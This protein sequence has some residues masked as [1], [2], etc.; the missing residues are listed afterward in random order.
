MKAYGL[1]SPVV[2]V[3]WAAVGGVL[4]VAAAMTVPDEGYAALVR[5][6][7]PLRLS[8]KLTL[9]LTFLPTSS[10]VRA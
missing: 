3:L 6:S 5:I 2:T 4:V 10:S 8:V 9:T 7:T 1:S